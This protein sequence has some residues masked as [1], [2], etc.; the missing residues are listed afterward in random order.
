MN[1]ALAALVRVV[2]MGAALAAY[3]AALPLLFPDEGG[4]ANIGAGLIA[5]AGLAITG[6]VWAL[7]DGRARGISASIIIWAV[8]AAVLSV[9]WLVALAFIEA[10]AGMSVAD[11]IGADIFSV[12]FTCGLIL[13]P[14]AVGAAIGG[15]LRPAVP[16]T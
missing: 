6:F 8:V 4:G 3:Y 14:A 13:V 12:L 5:F 9:A 1:I 11:R 10:D 2:T 16:H 7:L 15:A